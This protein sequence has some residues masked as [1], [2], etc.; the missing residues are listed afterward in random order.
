M[1]RTVSDRTFQN[2]DGLELYWADTPGPETGSLLPVLCIPGLTRNHRDFEAL[3][4]RMSATRRVLCPDLRGRGRSA[5]D[6][7]PARYVPENYA[8]DLVELLDHA[9][10]ERVAILGTSLGGMLAMMLAVLHPDRVERIA[11]NDIGPEI[12]P[13]GLARIRSYVGKAAAVRSWEEAGAAAKAIYQVAY[14]DL[15]D[16]AWIAQARLGSV[17]G[18]DGSIRPDYDP[19]ISQATGSN[20]AAAPDLWPIWKALGDRPILAIRGATS[21]ILSAATL[22]RMASE[23]PQMVHVTVPARGHAPLLDEPESLAALDAFFAGG[24]A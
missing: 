1:A 17:E 11:L 24:P 22:A 9:G 2:R 20:D 7:E 21:D 8:G 3:A 18:A 14:P 15:D 5:Y 19:A 4:V 10:V 13:S 16:A 12:D 6:P 23:A